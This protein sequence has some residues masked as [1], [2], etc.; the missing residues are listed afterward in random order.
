MNLLPTT[1]LEAVNAMLNTIGESPVNSL[2]ISGVSEVSIAQSILHNTSRNYQSTGRYWNTEQDYPLALD[3]DGFIQLPSNTLKVDTTYRY[4][5]IIQRGTRL[6]DLTNHTYVF[7]EVPKVEITF[8]LPFEELPQLVRNYITIAA[9]RE[10][11]RKQ[12]GSDTLNA[13][14][15]ED[16]MKAL[17]AVTE[18][19]EDVA[20]YSVF[21]NY[22]VARAINRNY[23]P[24]PV[25][26]R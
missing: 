19:E 13:L 23:N 9:G 1:E 3:S 2:I 18:F 12:V 22:S 6:Y 25:G 11:Q 10:F 4:L 26:A 8:F 16:E 24:Y 7:T 14:T 5:N 21:D 15:Q 20:D 17:V